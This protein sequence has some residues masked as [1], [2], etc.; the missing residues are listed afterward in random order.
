SIRQM[1]GTGLSRDIWDRFQRRFA[2]PEILE[3]WG[4]T[5]AN[6]SVLNVDN[7]PGAVGRIPFWEKS[8]V[9]FVRYDVENDRHL[10]GADG[11]LIPCQPGEVGE[12]IGQISRDPD[13][14]GGKF[15]GY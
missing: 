14:S 10:R 6:L 15:E 3:S 2:I 12:G 11:R 9:R 4:A 7:E 5:E 1:I 8:N 13:V